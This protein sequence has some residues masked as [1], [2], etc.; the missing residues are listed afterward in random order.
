[1]KRTITLAAGQTHISIKDALIHIGAASS[2]PPAVEVLVAGHKDESGNEIA[3]GDA[4]IIAIQTD[5]KELGLSRLRESVLSFCESENIK[6]RN[7]YAP[8][9][10]DYDKENSYHDDLYELTANEFAK[11]ASAYKL[12]VIHGIPLIPVRKK[13]PRDYKP[14]ETLPQAFD[15]VDGVYMYQQA[16]REIADTQGWSESKL[17]ALEADMISA[18]NKGVLPIRSRKTGM[19]IRPDAL[20]SG[21][22]LVTPDDVNLWLKNCGVPYLW[23]V[24]TPIAT[25]ATAILTTTHKIKNRTQ[26]LDAEIAIA[27]KTALDSNDPNSVWAELVKMAEKQTGCLLG[28]DE[29]SIRYQSGDDVKF[30]KKRSLNE[31][32]NRAATR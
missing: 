5:G 27:K 28:P 10:L 32:M 11:I 22:M 3:Q 29:N 15:V 12:E 26:P 9:I 2:F 1:M 4:E 14:W 24:A 13:S 6:P 8:G 25:K 31:R 23:N 7:P 16:A 21:L 17:E 30:F 19:V 20:D 18:I